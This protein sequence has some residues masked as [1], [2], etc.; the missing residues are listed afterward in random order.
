MNYGKI[1][2]GT[3]NIEIPQLWLNGRDLVQYGK[4]GVQFEEKGRFL[5]NENLPF[6]SD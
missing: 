2:D 3:G 4:I 5:K 6:S 1:S